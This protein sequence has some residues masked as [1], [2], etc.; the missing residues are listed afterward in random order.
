MYYSFIGR[1]DRK[2]I[3]A[4]THSVYIC[5]LYIYRI[6][7]S[8]SSI[9]IICSRLELLQSLDISGMP[10]SQTCMNIKASRPR[11]ITGWPFF[12]FIVLTD[13]ETNALDGVW[14][15]QPLD[16]MKYQIDFD[17]FS[18]FSF[19][20]NSCHLQW[21]CFELIQIYDYVLPPNIY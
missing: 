2:R 7:S 8:S 18:F 14:P 15:Q 21:F 19:L 11:A 3:P 20:Y 5:S 17:F 13:H 9:V 6:K 10:S 16:L 1:L 4:Y 12:L